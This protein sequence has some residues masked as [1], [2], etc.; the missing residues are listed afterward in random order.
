MNIIETIKKNYEEF[1]RSELKVTDFILENPTAVEMSTITKIATDAKTSTSAVLR[2][3]QTLGFNG[4][5]D[6]RFEMIEYL[7][8]NK[9]NTGSESF[10]GN[11]LDGYMQNIN[12]MK[13]IDP[14]K[15]NKLISALMNENNNYVLGIYYSSLPAREL[16]LGLNDLGKVSLF[17]NDYMISE[18]ITRT[19]DDDSTVLLFSIDGKKAN[20][21]YYLA[22]LA[23]KMPDNSFLITMNPKAEL[24]EVFPNTIV[25]PGRV[26]SSKSVIDTQSLPMIFV[27]LLLNLIQN[28]L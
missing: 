23:N 20:F 24:A 5:K 6:F 21:K 4:Y 9:K 26:F 2:F 28:K 11:L 12:Q 13:D 10:T 22:D 3:C 1:S 8:S 7:H 25:L 18:H 14:E 16:Y 27:E 19:V 15:I 17:A